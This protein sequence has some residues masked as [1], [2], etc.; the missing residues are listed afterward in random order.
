MKYRIYHQYRTHAILAHHLKSYCCPN[1]LPSTTTITSLAH[2]ILLQISLSFLK[3]YD[4]IFNFI[5]YLLYCERFLT[6]NNH[7][8]LYVRSRYLPIIILTICKLQVYDFL[9]YFSHKEPDDDY[10][11]ADTCSCLYNCY[12]IVVY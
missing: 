6:C 8:P 7:I 5:Q 4:F 10:C 9:L 1:K 11:V 2:W 12:S 3:I